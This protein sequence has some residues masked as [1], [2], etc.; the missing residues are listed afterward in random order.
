MIR[1]K[2]QEEVLLQLEILNGEKNKMT[3]ESSHARIDEYV[4]ARE[5][6]EKKKDQDDAKF[7][8]NGQSRPEGRS[9]FSQG[10]NTRPKQFDRRLP[11]GYGNIVNQRKDGA[12]QNHSQDQQKPS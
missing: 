5:H 10:I 2:L 8:K 4:T 3:V 11:V 6:V 1:A 12:E 9:R 7:K